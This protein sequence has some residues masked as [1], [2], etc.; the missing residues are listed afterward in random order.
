MTCK[1]ITSRSNS[2]SFRSLYIQFSSLL[3]W[4]IRCSESSIRWTAARSGWLSPILPAARSLWSS[5][6]QYSAKVP[7]TSP[8]WLANCCRAWPT[9][10]ESSSGPASGRPAARRPRTSHSVDPHVGHVG[11]HFGGQ[12]QFADPPREGFHRRPVGVRRVQTTAGEDRHHRQQQ[13][14]ADIDFNADR[15]FDQHG[16]LLRSPICV[17]AVWRLCV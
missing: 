5:R 4:W 8:S 14:D 1:P 12:R 16:I 6:L 10:S 2:L 11:A 13:A 17:F 15:P 7:S 3:A 9:R